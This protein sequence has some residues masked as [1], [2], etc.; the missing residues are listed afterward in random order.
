MTEKRTVFN[1]EWELQVMPP[2]LTAV[3]VDFSRDL[4]KIWAVSKE[5]EPEEIA[6]SE[7]AWHL[8]MPFFFLD[9]K[10]FCICPREVILDPDRYKSHM[11]HIMSVDTSFPLAIIWWKDR[12]EILDGL[13]RLCKVVIEGK[14]VIPVVKIPLAWKERIVPD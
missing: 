14:T 8:D 13:H 1:A 3:C 2:A 7:L 10:P 9:G 11:E 5:L 6:V 4:R 12:W